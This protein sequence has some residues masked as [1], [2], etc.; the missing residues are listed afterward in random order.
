MDF[1]TSTI[2]SGI[3][4][5]LIKKGIELSY[6]RVF[7]DFWGN[8]MRL[9]DPIYGEFLDEINSKKTIIEKEKTVNKLLESEPMASTFEKNLYNT[10]FAKR[11]DYIIS[12]IN[13]EKTFNRKVNLEFL[14]EW[15][16]FQSV[17]VLK[18]YYIK[19]IEPDFQFIENI[20][21]KMG[22]NSV[23]LKTGINATPF[24]SS[25]SGEDYAERIL[26]NEIEGK[27]IFAIK[28]CQRRREILVMKRIN[29]IKYLVF[30]RPIVFH[31]D[32]GG[33][34]R[35][36]LCSTYRFLNELFREDSS[37]LNN[38]HFIPEEVFEKLIEGTVYPGIVN[39]Y[40]VKQKS[41]ILYDFIEINA[42]P[43]RREEYRDQYGDEFWESQ[44]IV[45]K[46]V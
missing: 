31:S 7:G 5:D 41:N 35:S 44:E 28:D 11:L 43:T 29:D 13:Q 17:N 38:V 14:A 22:V 16:D 12:L 42:I 25:V 18:C 32:V 21:N 37:C 9:N 1:L 45:K 39:N 19:N 40:S 10:E 30:Q 2:I 23:W 46:F 27:Y 36:Q 4:Y 3:I 20:A 6:Q 24:Q 33:T 8:N 15:L 34:G 26:K